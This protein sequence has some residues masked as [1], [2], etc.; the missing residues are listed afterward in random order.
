VIRL[1]NIV[2]LGAIYSKLEFIKISIDIKFTNPKICSFYS[3]FNLMNHCVKSFNLFIRYI[4]SFRNMYI[5][6]PF[7]F[8]REKQL[9]LKSFI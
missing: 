9:S 8:W 5:T 4:K 6:S 7:I 2:C 3:L 1:L